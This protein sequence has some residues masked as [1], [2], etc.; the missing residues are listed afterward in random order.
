[1]PGDVHHNDQADKQSSGQDLAGKNLLVSNTA[2]ILA[3]CMHQCMIGGG[4]SS[5]SALCRLG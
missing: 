4:V 1:M 3:I 5:G 2:Q